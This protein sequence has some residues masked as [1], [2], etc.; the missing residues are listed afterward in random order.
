[1]S[2][3]YKFRDPDGVY[4]ITF[5]TVYWIDVFPNYHSF[6]EAQRVVNR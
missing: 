1:M 2:R 3:K 5:G 6:S 4:F